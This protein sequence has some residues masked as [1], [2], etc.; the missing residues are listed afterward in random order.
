LSRDN[1]AQ[2]T[3]IEIIQDPLAIQKLYNSL[4]Q[5][6][7][8]EILLLLPTTSAFLREEKMGIIQS[9]HNAA[10]RG[11]KIKVLTPTDEK[12]VPKM[13]AVLQDKNNNMGIRRVR[14][15][16]E[17]ETSEEARTKILVVDRKA[18][19]VV[20]LKDDSKETFVEAV[21][22]AIH[23]TT[24]STVKSYITLF[25][26]LWEQSELYDKLEAHDKMQREFINVAAHEL[27]TPIQPILISIELL[28][29]EF[30]N[31][32]EEVMITKEDLSLL[33]RNAKRLERLS[34]AILE[35]TRIEGNSMRLNKEKFDINEKIGNVINDVKGLSPPDKKLEIIND[36]RD[37]IFV[38]ADKLRIFEVISNL[39]RNAIKFTNEGRIVVKG[40][41]EGNNLLVQVKD[42]GTGIDPDIKPRLF[43]KFAT[44][45]DQG[46]GLGLFISK[47]IVEAHGGRIWAEDNPDGRGATFS[48]T[49]PLA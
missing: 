14:Y 1:L 33:F 31:G 36:T 34:S 9:L 44:K 46:T 13:E 38:K 12:I 5:S 22:L 6:A 25:E 3:G 18:Y 37:S 48:F 15:K 45:S 41:R 19:L 32:K 21:R 27:K 24:Q 35:V 8:R 10:N 40:Q 49:L 23:S 26:S 2:A 42:T 7:K 43:T 20:E 16:S 30:R 47:S 39:V 17:A 28:E 11:V 29:Q 4:V